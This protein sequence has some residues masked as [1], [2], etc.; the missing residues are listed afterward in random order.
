[1]SN[2]LMQNFNYFFI[3]KTDHSI[4]S[5]VHIPGHSP[6]CLA[7]SA[8]VLGQHVLASDQ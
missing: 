2:K 3:L 6:G 7:T 8:G 5:A 4:N 1:M